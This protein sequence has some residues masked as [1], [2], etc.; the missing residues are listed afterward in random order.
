MPSLP[1]GVVP[2]P[3]GDVA[4]GTLRKVWQAV[5]PPSR[6]EPLARGTL[7]DVAGGVRV[8]PIR[9]DLVKAEALR[10]L[11]PGHPGRE[12]ILCVADQVSDAEF[13]ALIPTWIKLLRLKVDATGGGR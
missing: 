4:A 12:A 13:D 1:V 9:L 8:M 6:H 3:F 5:R 11:P 2:I 7:Q 10:S